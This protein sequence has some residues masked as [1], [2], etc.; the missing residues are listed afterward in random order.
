MAVYEILGSVVR[1]LVSV[2]LA[3]YSESLYFHAFFAYGGLR[4]KMLSIANNIKY[5]D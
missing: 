5:G 2:L 3:L 4:F 1:Y